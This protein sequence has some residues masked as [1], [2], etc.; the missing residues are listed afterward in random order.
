MPEKIS[1]ETQNLRRKDMPSPHEENRLRDLEA[2]DYFL[3]FLHRAD[4]HHDL[5][6][7]LMTHVL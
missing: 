6:R 5:S 1:G 7:K 3:Q 2:I 4:I